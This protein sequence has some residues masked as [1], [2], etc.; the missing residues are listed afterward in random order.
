MAHTALLLD[1]GP[2]G[3][4]LIW[5][6]ATGSGHVEPKGCDWLV[7]AMHVMVEGWPVEEVDDISVRLPLSLSLLSTSPCPK[8]AW[9]VGGPK[10]CMFCCDPSTGPGL[11]VPALLVVLIVFVFDC[12][13]AAGCCRGPRFV[14][15]VGP[16]S[17]DVG[18][19]E[20]CMHH[21]FA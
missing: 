18:E 20:G 4:Q 6:E 16:D 11:P 21:F 7:I 14:L 15:L 2:E 9:G 10:S 12:P 1:V 17:W 5:L 3:C 8:L 19:L 13:S